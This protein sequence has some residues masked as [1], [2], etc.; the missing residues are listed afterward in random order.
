MTAPDHPRCHADLKALAAKL[1]RPLHTLYVLDGQTDP[2]LADQPSRTDRANWFFVLYN[3]LRIGLGVHVRHFFYK[4]I[5]QRDLVTLVNGNPLENTV[6][7]FNQLGVAIRDARYLDLIPG[8]AIIDRRNPAPIIN[9]ESDEDVGAEIEINHGAVVPFAFGRDYRP[10]LYRLPRA[11]LVQE[12]S[13]GQRY[14]LEI[15]IEK[16]T[17]ND[18][19]LQL[20]REYGINVCTFVGEVSATACKKLVDR[21]IASGRP[22][23]IFHV[24]DFDPGGRSMPVAAARKIQFEIDK[25][26]FDLDI[27]FEPVAL[28]PEQCIQYELPRK[29]IKESESRAAKFEARFGAGMTELDALEALHPGVLRQILVEHI[30]RYR[31][32]DLDDRIEDAVEQYREDLDRAAA[33]VRNRHAEELAAFD[34]QRDAIQERFEEARTAAEAARAAIAD[35]AHAAY[36]DIVQP[37]R[38][39]YEAIVAAAQRDL[40]AIVDEADDDLATLVQQAEDVRDEIIEAARD[41]IAAME[42]PLVAQV[43]TLIAQVN[44]EFDEVVPDPD[45]FDWPE[46]AADEWDD[47]LYDSTRGYVEQVD[48]FREYQGEDADVRLAEDRVVTKT[49]FAPDC[50]KVFETTARLGKHKYC[51]HLCAGRHGQQLCRDRRKRQAA[52]GKT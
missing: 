46:P 47:P 39:T 32:D 14:H 40:D 12:P 25:S 44:A 24:I 11:R 43:E 42:H 21:A 37:A 5:S 30:E 29:P 6:E 34:R 20:G 3:Q 52:E 22:V 28:T 17:A 7:C 50:L 48:R 38:A 4:L 27:R 31:D 26:G 9:F 36:D 23:R 51:S 8:D 10:P 33:L 49:C 1:R 41:E 18:V 45:Q 2:Y 35:P 19:L 15:W 16:S 13:F